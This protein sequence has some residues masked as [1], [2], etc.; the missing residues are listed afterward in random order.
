MYSMCVRDAKTLRDHKTEGKMEGSLVG[1]KEHFLVSP[2]LLIGFPR[3][4]SHER[5]VA[6][7]SLFFW[8]SNY[9]TGRNIPPVAPTMYSPDVASWP[10]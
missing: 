6:H 8:G 7:P 1:I 2:M 3:H 9:G 4:A 5:E 10:R